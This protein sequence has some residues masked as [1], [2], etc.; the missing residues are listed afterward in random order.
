MAERPDIGGALGTAAFGCICGFAVAAMWLWPWNKPARVRHVDAG[1][2]VVDASAP[3]ALATVAVASPVAPTAAAAA[4][5]APAAAPRGYNVIFLTVD[6]LR[7]D[8]GYMGYPKPIT[9]NIDALAARSVVFERTYATASFTPKSLGPLLIGKY[10]SETSRDFEH[11]TTFYSSN[12]F[13]AERIHASGARTFAGM[14]H[15]YFT[16]RTGL[17]QGF[18][19]WDTT[20]MP[21]NMTDNDRRVTSDRLTNVALSL[22]SKPEN[23]GG[24]KRF[25][26]WFH[27]FDPHLPYVPHPGSP[28]FRPLDG[29]KVAKARAPYDEEVW[30]TDQQIGRLLAYVASQP[31]G[32]ETAIVLT[33]DHGEA[34][35]EHSHIGHGRELWEP[36]VRVPLIVYVP[37]LAPKHVSVK[38]SHIDL[39][40]TLMQL[41]GAPLPSDRSLRGTSLVADLLAPATGP[42]VERDVY[43]DMPEGPFN[44]MRR[45]LITNGSPGTKLI[46]VGGKRFELYDLSRDPEEQTNLASDKAAMT[47]YVEGMQRLRSQLQEIPAR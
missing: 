1:V 44:E 29:S 11:Y 22:L 36:L 27:Y 39:A 46:D 33:A 17:Q 42:F 5:P 23:V 13:V 2:S 4:A 19:V 26:A 20:A 40:P 30:F 35:G 6:T 38:R 31:W 14:C 43:I 15:R 8:L 32:A 21:P 9:P 10:A 25:F 28:D 24:P 37:G 18:D 16:F 41:A 3:V 7:Y 47:P 12:V 45:A 34:F